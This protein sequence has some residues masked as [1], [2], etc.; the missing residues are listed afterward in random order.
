MR[1]KV[2]SS[3]DLTHTWSIW[4][5][6]IEVSCSR[7]T[8]ALHTVLSHPVLADMWVGNRAT[9]ENIRGNALE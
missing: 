2:S 7:R 5:Q 6:E 8:R 3:R 1:T 9:L 4:N